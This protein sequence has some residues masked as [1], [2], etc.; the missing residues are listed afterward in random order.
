MQKVYKIRII[1]TALSTSNIKEFTVLNISIITA[2]FPLDQET[3]AEMTQ[4]ITQV[5]ELDNTCY[6]DTLHKAF[7]ND[8][9]AKGFV[10]LAYD[11]DKDELVAVGSAMDLIG[12]HTFEWSLVVS[13]MYR[14]IG[15]GEAIFDILQEGFAQ[16]G[17]EG[18][19][20]TLV[21]TSQ[22][23]KKFIAKR[24]YGYSFSEA[25]LEAKPSKMTQPTTLTITA[26]QDEQRELAAIFAE[27][28]GDILEESLELIAHN[29]TTAGCKLWVVRDNDEVVGTFTTT[30]RGTVQWLTAI[31]VKKSQQGRGIGTTILAFAKQFALQAGSDVIMLDVEIDNAKALAIY[32][33]AG[34]LI[35][36]QTDYYV[37]KMS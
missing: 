18:D 22:A 30:S 12:L 29:T 20:A 15:L 9:M 5:N 11:D 17:S 6:D 10:V 14:K 26:Y 34:F 33:K 35:S 4:L 19:L 25:T 7:A 13:P 1:K 31:A 3:Y 28:F 36:Q 32:E 21:H 16:R 23:G 2:S 24:N 27:A 37:K 8:D